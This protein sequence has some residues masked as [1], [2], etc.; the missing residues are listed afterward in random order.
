MR[1]IFQHWNCSA[2]SPP[3]RLARWYGLI[4]NTSSCAVPFATAKFLTSRLKPCSGILSSDVQDK[5]SAGDLTTKPEAS[6]ETKLF[7]SCYCLQHACIGAS[8]TG[9]LRMTRTPAIQVWA[10]TSSTCP[11]LPFRWEDERRSPSSGLIR[12][13]GKEQITESQSR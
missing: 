13:A 6:R 2:E 9:T 5:S 12:I 4:P 10:F 1:P 3:V 7:A 11:P 8:T